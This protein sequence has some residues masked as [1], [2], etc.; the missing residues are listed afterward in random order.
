MPRYTSKTGRDVLLRFKGIMITVP[1][2]GYFETQVENLEDL[3]PQQVRKDEGVVW[4]GETVMF[5]PRPKEI[6]MTIPKPIDVPII[7]P[8]EMAPPKPIIIPVIHD[9]P[10]PNIK[11]FNVQVIHDLPA[12]IIKNIDIPTLTK[13]PTLPI[14]NIVVKQKQAKTINNIVKEN[15]GDPDLKSFLSMIENVLVEK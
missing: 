2:D 1:V 5:E 4:T 14:R 15:E 13:L 10:A 8:I 9:L 7:H 11:D 12:P 3:F 6:P